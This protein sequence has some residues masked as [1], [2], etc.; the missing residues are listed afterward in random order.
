M[1]L[2][3]AYGEAMSQEIRNLRSRE[4]AA[5]L[6]GGFTNGPAELID[7]LIPLWAGITL[8]VGASQIGFLV[9]ADLIVSVLARP[10]ATWLADTRERRTLAGIGAVL[11]VLSCGGYAIADSM[12]I[13][14]LA[15]VLGGVGGALLWV[16]LRAIIGERLSTD[17]SVFARLMSV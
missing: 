6:A 4:G 14:S 5:L 10:A 13:A 1:I 12:A 15:A 17:S 8:D 3:L 16:S 11:Y 9:A 7:F 2:C